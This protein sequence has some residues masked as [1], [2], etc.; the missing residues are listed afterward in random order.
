MRLSPCCCRRFSSRA[1]IRTG[2]SN[3]GRARISDGRLIDAS[4]RAGCRP[5][6]LDAVVFRIRDEV[7]VRRPGDR[8][9]AVWHRQRCAPVIPLLALSNENLW[10][11]EATAGLHVDD[12]PLI[13]RWC[14]ESC[15]H[16]GQGH[17]WRRSEGTDGLVRTQR[18]RLR[19]LTS[20]AD[21]EY[22]GLSC[23]S[24]VQQRPPTGAHCY[25]VNPLVL[26]GKPS[27]I[28]DLRRWRGDRDRPDIR[29]KR[30][31]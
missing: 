8:P 14:S 11:G 20:D 15:E 23:A 16:A 1:A 2:Y 9:A 19:S 31:N 4:M 27:G 10:R 6:K 28:G 13:G 26:R 22:C 24:G 21:F 17:V 12:V 30:L 18:T 25:R 7:A 29:G 5:I 3:R